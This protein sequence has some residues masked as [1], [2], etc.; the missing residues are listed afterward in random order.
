MIGD[1]NVVA[2][3]HRNTEWVQQSSGCGRDI[4]A[5]ALDRQHSRDGR[6]GRLRHLPH[7]AIVDIRLHEVPAIVERDSSRRESRRKRR[8][9]VQQRSA[10]ARDARDDASRQLHLPDEAITAVGNVQVTLAVQRHIRRE[11]ERRQGGLHS[12]AL[13]TGLPVTGDSRNNALHRN[14][15]NPEVLL[16]GHVDV[17]R[18]IHAEPPRTKE[19]GGG[20]WP[21]VAGKARSCEVAR[22]GS[23]VTGGIH[24]DDD[25]SAGNVQIARRIDGYAGDATAH[26][27]DRGDHAG[28][29]HLAHT[30]VGGIGDVQVARRVHGETLR[31][32][33]L[34]RGCR[35]AIAAEA[36]C[37][38]ACVRGNHS[39]RRNLKY[40]VEI[41]VADVGVARGIHGNET[42]YHQ[43]GTNRRSARSKLEPAIAGDG[44]DVVELRRSKRRPKQQ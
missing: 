20:G 27:R 9:A 32:E 4:I 14:L 25:V 44:G 33:E 39:A 29:R 10:P 21:S 40:L 15:A 30:V 8:H 41:R 2:A 43:F 26:G 36:R 18:G 6:N 13:V 22:K 24:F 38:V 42:R 17:A 16:I 19:Q 3:V 28:R 34:R 23:D 1:E 5:G 31:I 11:R 7:P 37:A 12:I 35:S